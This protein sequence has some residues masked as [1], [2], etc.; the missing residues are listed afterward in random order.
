MAS[1]GDINSLKRGIAQGIDPNALD[2]SHSTGMHV[3]AA[4]NHIQIMELLLEAGARLDSRDYN[5]RTL[6]NIEMV[7]IDTHTFLNS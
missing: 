7:C 2:H 5:V 1:S 6:S 4:N 3:A